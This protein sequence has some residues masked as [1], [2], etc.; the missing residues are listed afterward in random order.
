MKLIVFSGSARPERQSHQVAEEVKSRLEQKGH[1][2]TMLDVRELNFPLLE[3]TFEKTAEP[4]EKLKATS[5]VIS[6][7]EGI[8]VVSPEHNGSYSGALKN[9]MDYY[10]NEYAY[11]PFGI[12]GVSS[13]MLGGV[14]A[15]DKLQQYA[16]TLKGIVLP[17]VM[18]TPKVQ[19]LFKDGKLIDSGYGERL[20]KFLAEFLEL[21]QLISKRQKPD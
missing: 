17:N 15:T 3:N 18:I 6:E 1:S 12:V 10:F 20:D 13:G 8:V 21:A 9:T 5:Q 16:L 2:V 19:T 14:K 11:K 7:S 4:W